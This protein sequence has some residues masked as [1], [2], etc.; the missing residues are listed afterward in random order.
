MSIIWKIVLIFA[1]AATVI[2]ATRF[3]SPGEMSGT[4]VSPQTPVA[5][6]PEALTRSAGPLRETK[7]DNYF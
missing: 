5:V 2:A 1:I 4:A 7:V 3:V 6:S